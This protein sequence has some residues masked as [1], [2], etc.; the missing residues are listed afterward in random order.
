MNKVNNANHE[1][2]GTHLFNSALQAQR[3]N[4]ECIK[5]HISIEI[6][7]LGYVHLLKKES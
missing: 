2:T 1:F 4:K 3:L 6:S 7:E 5:V